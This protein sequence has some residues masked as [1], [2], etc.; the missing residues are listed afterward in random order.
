MAIPGQPRKICLLGFADSRSQAPFADESWEIWGVNDVYFHVPRVDRSFELHDLGE[1]MTRR[2][3][4]YHEHLKTTKVPTYMWERHE[5][6]P[7][8][9]AMP[10]DELIRT[11]GTYFTNSVSWM[12]ALAIYELTQEV[13][14]PNG[15]KARVPL[16]GSEICLFGIDMAHQTEYAAQRPSVEYFVGL[17]RGMGIPVHI[18]DNSDIC[19]SLSLYGI[20]TTAPFRKRIKGKLE[21]LR[22]EKIKLL[23]QQQQLAAQAQMVDAQIQ[24]IRGAMNQLDYVL[25][26]WTMP[27]DIELNEV[28]EAKDRGEAMPGSPA[29]EMNGHREPVNV[30][31]LTNG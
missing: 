30:G 28:L 14:L 31:D 3:P 7:A 17:A 18:P 12:V 2:N 4:G 19:K 5:E 22:Q 29:L 25:G 27:T 13:E 26:V 23:G 11:F 6:W 9:V 21:H 20:E 16:P 1:L 15:Q 10:K 8:S 24:Q